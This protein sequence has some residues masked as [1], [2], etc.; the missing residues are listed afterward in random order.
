[1]HA[2]E[3]ALSVSLVQTGKLKSIR[4]GV[5]VRASNCMMQ[6]VIE[7]H[8]VDRVIHEPVVLHQVQ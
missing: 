7:G 5:P 6:C 4:P 3:D 1:M 8:E 2:A